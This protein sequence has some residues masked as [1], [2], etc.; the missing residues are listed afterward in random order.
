MF[1]K[2]IAV[3][4]V[5]IIIAI[6]SIGAF[7]ITSEGAVTTGGAIDAKVNDFQNVIE[8][9]LEQGEAVNN[10]ETIMTITSPD[11]DKDS[12]YIK[13]YILSGNSRHND[14]KI[15]IARYNEDTNTYERMENTDGE[16]SWDIGDFRLFSKEI[17]LNPGTNKIMIMSY[18][19]SNLE[20]TGLQVNCF[21]IELLDES[22]IGKVI[23]RAKDILGDFSW[24]S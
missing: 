18:R 20:E 11:E 24:I 17:I 1:K 5:L 22:I 14:V 12:T 16:S 6:S 4:L 2:F 3:L 23:R 10:D 19:T 7:A 8:N 9:T 15:I 21:T 13:S